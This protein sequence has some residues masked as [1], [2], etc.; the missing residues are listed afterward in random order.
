MSTNSF[1]PAERPGKVQAIGIL[2]V[3]DG[4]LNLLWS[5]TLAFIILSAGVATLGLGCL[6]LPLAALPMV[7][8]ILA[9]ISGLR[10]LNDRERRA[11]PDTGIAVLQ[12][13]NVLSGNVISLG[14]GIAALVLYSDPEV[15][16]YFSDKL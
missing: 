6:F 7:T 5:P 4:V 10:L 1:P 16:D 2:N 3:I 15:K 14:I 13:V 9:L 12:I 11:R 8:G